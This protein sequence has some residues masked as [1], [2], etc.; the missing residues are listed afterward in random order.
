MLQDEES[1]RLNVGGQPEVKEEETKD[2][3]SVEAAQLCQ[4]TGHLE[5]EVSYEMETNKTN[6]ESKSS[7][8]PAEERVKGLRESNQHLKSKR[9]QDTE[10]T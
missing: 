2:K 10:I 3:V 5:E 6:A 7:T 8:V 1:K 4:E 9:P